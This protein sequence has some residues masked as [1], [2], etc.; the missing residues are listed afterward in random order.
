LGFRALLWA[1]LLSR[2][3]PR[4]LIPV[5]FSAA[6]RITTQQISAAVRLLL[7]PARNVFISQNRRI[8]ISRK[9]PIR[10]PTSFHSILLSLVLI[11]P[12]FNRVNGFVYQIAPGGALSDSSACCWIYHRQLF[13]CGLSVRLTHDVEWGKNNECEELSRRWLRLYET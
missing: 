1:F 4:K 2:F 10:H 7:A 11:P 13:K 9:F 6:I 3:S 5:P 8:P 12:D